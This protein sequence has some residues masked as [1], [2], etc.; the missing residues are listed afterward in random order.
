MEKEALTRIAFDIL[1]DTVITVLS[2]GLFV[3]LYFSLTEF[4][5]MPNEIWMFVLVPI[6]GIYA[7]M[8]TF[9]V[10][11]GNYRKPVAYFTYEELPMAS[12]LNDFMVRNL[13]YYLPKVIIHSLFI[14]LFFALTDSTLSPL[15]FFILFA[16]CYYLNRVI[17]TEK[18]IYEK[19]I[20]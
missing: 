12:N 20:R 3:F 15:I 16:L 13:K 17:L 18:K 1:F 6:L 19:R 9:Y 2:I 5:P 11:Y 4:P 10:S 8:S 7:L 14:S